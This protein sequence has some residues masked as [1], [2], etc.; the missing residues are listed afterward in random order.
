MEPLYGALGIPL[1]DR[2]QSG[3]KE[4]TL[5]GLCGHFVPSSQLRLPFPFRERKMSVYSLFPAFELLP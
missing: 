2:D 1:G 4:Q 3:Y 5:R